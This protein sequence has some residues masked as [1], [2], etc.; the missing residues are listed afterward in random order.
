MNEKEKESSSPVPDWDTFC[1]IAFRERF[2]LDRA[3]FIR[4]LREAEEV[5]EHET[6]EEAA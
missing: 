3:E 6:Q 2:V 1:R 5:P 4:R